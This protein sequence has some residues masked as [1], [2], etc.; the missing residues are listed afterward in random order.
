MDN[1]FAT[2]Y[3]QRP[4]EFGIDFVVHSLTKGLGGFGTDMGGV[5]IGP[6]HFRDMLLLF[7]KDFGAVLGTKAAWS[8]LT[9][10]LPTLHLRL[11]RQIKNAIRVAEFLEAH[12]LIE[13]VNYPGLPSFRYYE[14]AKKQMLDFQG[15]FSP[16]SLIY[17]TL[18][19]KDFAEM[20]DNG[21]RF[22]NYAAENAYTLTL[23][24]SLGHTRTL[25]EHPAS[26]THS[27]I[28]PEEL[29]KAGIHPGGIRLAVGLENSDDLITD[30]N[31][32]L[33]NCQ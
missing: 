30:L 32:C 16:G 24:V 25:M 22:M 17:F 19:G 9:Y 7:R 10:G 11:Q 18:K 33:S 15:N 20:K 27:M 31:A 23:A 8:I 6:A 13:Y 3:C 1:T 5:V 26:M 2:P 29:L 28:P 14:T 4:I 21:K 12:P